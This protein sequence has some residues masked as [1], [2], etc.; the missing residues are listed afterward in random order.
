MQDLIGFEANELVD[1][2]GVASGQ[3]G[4][5]ICHLVDTYGSGNEENN[6]IFTTPPS[7]KGVSIDVYEQCISGRCSCR[8]FIGKD[9]S[10]M[11]PCRFAA[12]LYQSN[13]TPSEEEKIMFNGIVDGFDIVS[14]DIESY[15]NSNYLSI[16][17][18][19]N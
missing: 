17:S 2:D 13:R 5:Q 16:L 6:L 19:E 9:L 18:E 4:K 10:Q 14:D 15:D 1:P 11:K 12:F 3:H 7:T 8:H